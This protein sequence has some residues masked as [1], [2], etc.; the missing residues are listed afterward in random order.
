MSYY[1]TKSSNV[2]RNYVVI[3][4]GIPNLNSMIMGVKFRNGWAVVEKGSKIY[5]QLSKLPMLKIRNEQPLSF[6]K[7]LPFITRALDVKLIYGADVYAKYITLDQKIQIET[8]IAEKAEAE[9]V[10]LES[11]IKC[12][13]RLDTGSLCRHDIL[14]PEVTSYC[15]THILKD[16]RLRE[17]G[18]KI[19]L[20]ST[21]KEKKKLRKTAFNKLK[22]YKPTEETANV[23]VVEEETTRTEESLREEA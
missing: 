23:E 3:R 22:D 17:M 11:E 8:E 12:K 10:H 20:A 16:P 1:T 21:S 7:Q 4:H 6:L 19:P 14:S 5:H 15:A 2:E 9:T 13:F 18:F